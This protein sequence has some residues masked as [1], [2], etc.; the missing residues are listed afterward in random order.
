MKGPEC[1]LTSV[2]QV[3]PAKL[4]PVLSNQS[5]ADAFRVAALLQILDIRDA[6]ETDRFLDVAPD[7]STPTTGEDRNGLP[8]GSEQP[9]GNDTVNYDLRFEL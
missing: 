7:L 6:I 9:V 2:V 4:M 5:Y 3:D 1:L 8:T